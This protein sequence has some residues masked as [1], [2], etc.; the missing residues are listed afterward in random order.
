MGNGRAILHLPGVDGRTRVVLQRPL[1]NFQ[2]FVRGKHNSAIHLSDNSRKG[3]SKPAP[4]SLPLARSQ[5]LSARNSQNEDCIMEIKLK[6]PKKPTLWGQLL[7]WLA[8]DKEQPPEPV[9]QVPKTGTNTEV[10][11]SLTQRES[12][13][14]TVDERRGYPSGT[15]FLR[16]QS[17]DAKSSPEVHI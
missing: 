1:Q 13:E 5:L 2:P 14:A 12:L 7:R 17:G 8:R 6:E 15:T 10:L 11:L 4:V 9:L 16:R 3:R